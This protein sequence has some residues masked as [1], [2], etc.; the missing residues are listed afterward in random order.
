MSTDAIVVLRADHT[1]V[2]TLFREFEEASAAAHRT[3]GLVVA[4]IIELLTVH[5]WL[6]NECLYPELQALVPGLEAAILES[7]EEHH[8]AE[9]LMAELAVM[10]PGDARFTAKT[11]VLIEHVEQHMDEEENTLFPRMREHLGRKQLQ[12]VGAR[13]LELRARTGGRTPAPLP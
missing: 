3:R 6:E 10:S 1:A 2:R 11:R 9:V 4:R 7:Y 5:T 8:I 13:M 12:D